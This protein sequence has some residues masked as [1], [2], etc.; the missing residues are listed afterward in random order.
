MHDS[1][2]HQRTQ[3]AKAPTPRQRDEMIAVAAYYLAEQR[4]FAPGGAESDWL[5][6]ECQ[7]D[8]LLARS[9]VAGVD[10]EELHRLRLRN[11]LRIWT[12]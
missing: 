4:G 2:P 9:S 12:I 8:Q 6:A 11:A 1:T 10:C 5:H 7:I 3:Q